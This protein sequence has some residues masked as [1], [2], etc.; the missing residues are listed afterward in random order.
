[1]SG[2]T[3][4]MEEDG[5]ELAS[6]QREQSAFIETS[7]PLSTD[8]LH[9]NFAQF[10]IAASLVPASALA[11]LSLA[12]A[13]LGASIGASQTGILYLCYTVTALSGVS[14]MLIQQFSSRK[15]LLI[16]MVMYGAYVLCFV[17]AALQE[18]T[19]GSKISAWLGA[20]VGGIG[21][22]IFWTAQGVYFSQAV[23]EYLSL[24]PDAGDAHS[25]WAGQFAFTFLI[26]ETVLDLL[27]TILVQNM[28][29]SWV[30]LFL[31]Y[32]FVVV[33]A[34]L[35]MLHAKEYSSDID[36]RDGNRHFCFKG[37]ISLQLCVNDRRMK[38]FLFFNVAFG[39]CGAFL[40]S[41]VNGQVVIAALGSDAFVG[42]LV[43]IH[44]G[45][46]AIFS[47]L[48][49]HVLAPRI[50]KLS[51]LIVGAIGFACVA[52]PFIIQPKLDWWSW[53]TLIL[54]YCSGG[55]GRASYEGNLKAIFADYF[56]DDKEAAF[57]NIILQHGLSSTV[58]YFWSPHLTCSSTNSAYCIAYRDGSMHSLLQ[59][60]T[61]VVA[62]S[63]AA[64]L[65]LLRLLY[66]Q[67][68]RNQSAPVTSRRMRTTNG[69]TVV[70]KQLTKESGPSLGPSLPEVS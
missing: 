37:S 27:A 60:V 29:V 30:I 66:L 57:A 42:I 53:G 28:G 67:S 40:N 38:Y 55:I 62:T 14:P 4:T 7:L 26:C 46:A 68:E 15:A 50:G 2:P 31:S 51:V 52:I 12:T 33:A 69:Y 24:F 56:V 23:S 61:V 59:S 18:T 13:R 8:D 70:K 45:T 34:T 19:T 20:A 6:L 21:A 48:F 32:A 63:C 16:G 65:G 22:G 35:T 43:A 11:C 41:F 25:R 36:S 17:V 5:I 9:R 39:F 44:G 3:V 10:S 47:L 58:A 49:G 54:V 64:I 1:M